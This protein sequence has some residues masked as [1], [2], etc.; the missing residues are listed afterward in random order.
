MGQF[1]R[2][3]S[4]PYVALLPVLLLVGMLVALA[5]YSTRATETAESSLERTHAIIDNLQ[6]ELQGVLNAETGQRG[7][8][9]TQNEDYLGHYNSARTDIDAATS[10]LKTLLPGDGESADTGPL[11]GFDRS[12][13]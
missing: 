2:K 9:L 3:I 4:S 10:A 8:L 11:A 1:V 12:E 13:S 7:Y 5:L 6:M